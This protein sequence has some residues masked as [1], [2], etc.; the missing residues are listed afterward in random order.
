MGKTVIWTILI[1][2][3][4]PPLNNIEGTN[5]QNFRRAMLLVR[6]IV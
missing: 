3:P 4:L 5:E 6:N 1:F 2:P